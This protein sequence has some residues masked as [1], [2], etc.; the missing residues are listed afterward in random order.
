MKRSI[1][2]VLTGS[3]V[4]LALA[5]PVAAFCQIGEAPTEPH[6]KPQTPIPQSHP[7]AQGRMDAQ[8]MVRGTVA[9]TRSLDARKD[10]DGSRFE[11]KLT[12]T[13]HLK[14]GKTL[15]KGTS[16]V[17][18]VENDD[19]QVAGKSKLAVRFTE[20]KLTNGE[21][22][23]IKATIVEVYPPAGLDS[24]GEPIPDESSPSY[25][26]DDRTNE[27]NSRQLDVDQIG[28]LKNV[29]LHSKLASQNS[30]VFVSTKSDDVKLMKG[31]R[32][33]LALEEN[34]NGQQAENR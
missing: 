27:W 18:T 28:A 12:R 16:L 22:I 6:Q 13:V 15:D 1:R 4:S 26:M 10:Q 14:N 19:M 3:A 20:A 7:T 23:P 2:N 8:Q 29:D 33:E 17:G 25:G 9:L 30:G 24:A 31:S 32:L 21:T 34:G 5:L 11:A